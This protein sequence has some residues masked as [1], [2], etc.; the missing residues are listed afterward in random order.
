MKSENKNKI[1]QRD[2]NI[3]NHF[4]RFYEK[5]TTFQ[6][7]RPKLSMHLIREFLMVEGMFI[8]GEKHGTE[9]SENF[10]Y[11]SFD[12]V[13]ALINTVRGALEIPY[14]KINSQPKLIEYKDSVFHGCLFGDLIRLIRNTVDPMITTITALNFL[15]MIVY[16]I[17]PDQ[18]TKKHKA[19]RWFDSRL[20][21]GG[22]NDFT[23]K[24]FDVEVYKFL[25]F[26]YNNVRVTDFG[27]NEFVK[28]E[29][30]YI[31]ERDR[32]Y[33]NE[34]ASWRRIMQINN[35]DSP[36]HPLDT[37]N[38]ALKVLGGSEFGRFE[39]AFTEHFHKETRIE[40]VLTCYLLFKESYL[41]NRSELSKPNEKF[42]VKTT[43]LTSHDFKTKYRTQTKDREKIAGRLREIG[44]F[45]DLIEGRTPSTDRDFLCNYE[46][47]LAAV[48]YYAIQHNENW[49]FL[50]VAG[51]RHYDYLEL[52][53]KEV[54]LPASPYYKNKGA[55][56]E[57]KYLKNIAN[58]LIKKF[59]VIK[60]QSEIDETEGLDI[61]Q[62]TIK[63]LKYVR[64]I[65][66]QYKIHGVLNKEEFVRADAVSLIKDYRQRIKKLTNDVQ[67]PETGHLIDITK[68][69]DDINN[70]IKKDYPIIFFTFKDIDAAKFYFR[71]RGL[72]AAE[73]TKYW[74]KYIN[75]N[76]KEDKSDS[77]SVSENIHNLKNTK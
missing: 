64:G 72:A 38:N 48:M 74:K 30:D 20:E 3:I 40:I 50:P 29:K 32:K 58:I 10:E 44:R 47:A 63:E 27:K 39:A 61:Y 22:L 66:N 21:V 28:Q 31:R 11:E 67:D 68:T 23:E 19:F 45:F 24:H 18:L 34:G 76:Y 5:N 35:D 42:N 13:E 26:L 71:K 41:F 77:G 15:I 56:H 43:S 60:Q 6:K 25:P 4:N 1:I 73:F 53:N 7:T 62:K 59:N 65:L 9:Y 52:K 51:F 75:P 54:G 16:R 55:T 12:N 37:Y 49:G 57:T 2:N 8:T 69:V 36:F 14:S 46:N 33:K 70:T 17:T